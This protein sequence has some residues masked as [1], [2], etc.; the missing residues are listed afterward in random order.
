METSSEEKLHKHTKE[1]DS[2]NGAEV[3]KKSTE[4]VTDEGKVL[5]IL[6]TAGLQALNIHFRSF[7]I[8]HTLVNE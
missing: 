2:K 4:R 8:I 3:H 7:S 5:K 1:V 6:D